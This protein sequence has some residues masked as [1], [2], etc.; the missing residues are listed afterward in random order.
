MNHHSWLLLAEEMGDG[1]LSQA[2]RVSEVDIQS[3]VSG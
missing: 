3:A 1:E 2:D